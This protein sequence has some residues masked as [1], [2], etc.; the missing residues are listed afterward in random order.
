MVPSHHI[1][2]VYERHNRLHTVWKTLVGESRDGEFVE[3]E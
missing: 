2:T 1:K 3:E